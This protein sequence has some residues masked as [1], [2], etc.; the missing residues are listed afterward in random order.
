[1]KPQDARSVTGDALH[2]LRT[3]VVAAVRR[4]MTQTE[5]AR[6]FAVHRSAVNR[7]CRAAA[8]GPDALRPRRRGRKP[9]GGPLTPNQDAVLAE[10]IRTRHPDDLGLAD[11]LWT[12]DAVAAYAAR[13][14]GVTRSRSVWGRWLRA[15]GFTPQR[16]ARRA[17]Q[18]DPADLARWRAEVYPRIKARAKAEKAEVHWVDESGLRTDHAPGTGYAPRGR[19]PV[20]RTAGRPAR[21]N[22]LSTVTNAG[23][24]RF[25]VFAG[26]FTAAVLLDFLRR[27]LRS[28]TGKVFLIAD[29]HPV[30]RSRKVGEWAERHADRVRLFFLPPYCPELNPTELLNNAVKGTVPRVRRARDKAELAGQVRSYLRIAQKRSAVVRQFFKA[31]PVRYAA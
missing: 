18:Q 17:Y 8:G 11:A 22:L 31:E 26:R 27:L 12:R 24:L 25:R 3:R 20:V 6:V 5:A 30:H 4:G 29:G 28:V 23:R 7:W 1:M 13:R 14:F 10:A 16:P 15:R 19:T 21:V 9:T 2:D